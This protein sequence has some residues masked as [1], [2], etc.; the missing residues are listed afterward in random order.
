MKKESVQRLVA[1]CLEVSLEAKRRFLEVAKPIW[2]RV[3]ALGQPASTFVVMTGLTAMLFVG[4]CLHGIVLTIERNFFS[5]KTVAKKNIPQPTVEFRREVV[6]VVPKP[7]LPQAK[8]QAQAKPAATVRAPAPKQIRQVNSIPQ[9][10]KFK[11]LVAVPEKKAKRPARKN[12]SADKAVADL[13]DGLAVVDR[14]LDESADSRWHA[15]RELKLSKR[16]ASEVLKRRRQLLNELS[17]AER[18]HASHLR[19]QIIDQHF[20]WARV[21]FGPQKYAR[22]REL[23]EPA[24]ARLTASRF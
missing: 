8:T 12:Q 5:S 10:P 15:L 4:L 6:K 19:G 2:R 18:T 1:R 13:R 17:I 21:Y 14:E 23:T 16:Q 11:H 24:L 7:A 9:E 20:N 3:Q 22:Y